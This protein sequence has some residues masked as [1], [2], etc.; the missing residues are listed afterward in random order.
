MFNDLVYGGYG[1][2]SLKPIY[3]DIDCS[4]ENFGI[5]DSS[6]NHRCWCVGTQEQEEESS[7][8]CD[9]SE[10]DVSEPDNELW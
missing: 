1:D 9:C 5:F 6:D 7:C 8:E 10:T 2:Y 4:Y 3:G